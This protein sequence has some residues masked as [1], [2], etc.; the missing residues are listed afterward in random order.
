MR[1]RISSNT[2]VDRAGLIYG[3]LHMLGRVLPAS[4]L[5]SGVLIVELMNRLDVGYLFYFIPDE[6]NV[7]V[8]AIA[9]DDGPHRFCTIELTDS[10]CVL[11]MLGGTEVYNE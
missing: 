9:E 7:E 3:M 11:D 6:E 10:G 2:G 8:L 1:H 5:W 4:P